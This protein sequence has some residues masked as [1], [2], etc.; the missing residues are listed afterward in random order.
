VI[1]EGLSPKKVSKRMKRG[2]QMARSI[3]KTI[4]RM[5]KE[6]QEF[7]QFLHEDLNGPDKCKKLCQDD[8]AVPAKGMIIADLFSSRVIIA[9]LHPGK[10]PSKQILDLAEPILQGERGHVRFGHIHKCWTR[11]PAASLVGALCANK[12]EV[13]FADPRGAWPQQWRSSVPAEEVE[14]EWWPAMINGR[15]PGTAA[16]GEPIVDMPEKLLGTEPKAPFHRHS[17]VKCVAG[18]VL[19]FPAWLPYRPAPGSQER[20]RP[21]SIHVSTGEGTTAGW[22]LPPV[23][24][25]CVAPGHDE[26]IHS[27][28]TAGQA[29]RH[30]EL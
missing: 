13:W 12:A 15:C 21:L 4:R 17:V 16:N 3:E 8:S 24:P 5:E 2:Y 20:I 9:S 22:R 6:P 27:Q 23:Q 28:A 29:E 1:I 19:L 14:S 18:E 11:D 26:E 7:I 10:D 25:K 30:A